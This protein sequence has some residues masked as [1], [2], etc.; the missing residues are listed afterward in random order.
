MRP[1]CY[2][3]LILIDT[4]YY[5]MNLPTLA[6]EIN[7]ID[8]MSDMN[9]VVELLKKRQAAIRKQTQRKVKA[10]LTHGSRV[11]I[12]ANEDLGI[13]TVTEMRRTK[14]DVE[15]DDGRTFEVPFT[16]LDINVA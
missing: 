11:L 14:C 6:A 2:N 7:S 5:I 13:C 4:E 16:M 10:S 15:T 8:N 9:T 1:V 3:N 12:R